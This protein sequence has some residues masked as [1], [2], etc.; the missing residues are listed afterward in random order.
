MA[1]RLSAQVDAGC[2]RLL[3]AVLFLCSCGP[4]RGQI[5]REYDIKAVFL[6]NFAQFVD[7]PAASFPGPETPFI[8]GVLGDDP[9]GETLGRVIGD[10]TI[11]GRRVVTERYERVEDIQLCHIL[12]VSR[13][14]GR[15]VRQILDALRT[16]AVLTVSDIG[17]FASQGGMIAFYTENA[18]VRL[19]INHE[20]ARTARLTISSKLLRVADVVTPRED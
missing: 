16:R 7:W 6:Y 17:G 10:D 1:A 11:R 9:F 13:S 20:A 12:F 5:S 18:K 3:L 4:A 19:R 8:I 14:E 2:A 15:R